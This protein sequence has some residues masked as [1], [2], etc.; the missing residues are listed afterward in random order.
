MAASGSPLTADGASAAEASRDWRAPYR[1]DLDLVLGPF[2]HGLLDPSIHVE[3]A[4]S[5]WLTMRTP[6]GPATLH[7]DVRPDGDV[8]LVR[9]R[10]WG[11]G[12]F[13]ALDGMPALLGDRDDPAG[14]PDDL[15]PATLQRDWQR[16]SARWRLPRS[17]RV[18]EALI[19]AVLEQKVTAIESRRSWSALLN[20]VGDLAPGPTPRPMRV[21]PE[22]D[23]IRRVP[24]W[25]WHRW[26][27]QPAQSATIVRAVLVAGRLEECTTLTAADARRRL[28]A[29]D[30]IGPWTVAEVGS[31]ALGDADAL[32][33]GDFHL[34]GQVVYAFTGATDGTDEQ[35]VDLLAPFAGHRHRVQRLVQT[36]AVRK[37]ARGPRATITDHRRR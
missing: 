5:C 25:Q 22:P 14:F 11:A 24:S 20:N 21:C 28:G 33:V 8:A 30:G 9:G 3:A 23:A 12:A 29:V 32:S 34:A 18:L 26:G 4:E 16:I 13:R 2:M 17:E 37:P 6:D 15:L 19:A 10:A 7:L 1:V 35:M 27:V 36:S 31:R